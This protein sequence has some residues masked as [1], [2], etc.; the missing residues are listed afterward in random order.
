MVIRIST[1]KENK[2]ESLFKVDFSGKSTLILDNEGRLYCKGKYLIPI[3][4]NYG[5]YFYISINYSL[6]KFTP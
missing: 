6:Y 3:T 1:R 2:H 4:I 5:S